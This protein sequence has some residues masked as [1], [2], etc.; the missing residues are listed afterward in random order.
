MI[1]MIKNFIIQNIISCTYS[2]RNSADTA[3]KS[4]IKQY[5]KKVNFINLNKYSTSSCPL[6]VSIYIK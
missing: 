2:L 6:F 4:P 5:A 1:L 3:I